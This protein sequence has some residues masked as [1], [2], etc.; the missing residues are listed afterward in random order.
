MR[1]IGPRV[2]D[3]A[4][5]QAA[6]NGVGFRLWQKRVLLTNIDDGG[7][8]LQNQVEVEFR[9]RQEMVSS[10]NLHTRNNVG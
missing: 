8:V 4:I 2:E 10:L 1:N 5:P 7:I 9:L 3:R 6:C